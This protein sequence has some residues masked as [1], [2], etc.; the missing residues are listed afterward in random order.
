MERLLHWTLL[1][2]WADYPDDVDT[3]FGEEL[4][5]VGR[6]LAYHFYDGSG[7]LELSESLQALRGRA[8]AGASDRDL[9]YVDIIAAIIRIRIASSAW[10]T[11][12]GF[13]GLTEEQW[14]PAIRRSDFPKELWPSQMMLGRAGIYSG[15][16]GIVQMP[17]SAGK[18]RAVEIVLR[19]A[20]LAARTRLAVVVAPFRALC[21]EI[22]TSLRHAF[23]DDDV[24]VNELSDAMQLDFLE[25][26]AELLECEI[27]TSSYILS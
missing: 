17:T 15:S 22:G 24:K 6:L 10:T 19:S 3:F 4:R 16:S 1:A 7:L 20:F 23:G 14:A 9:L 18:T 21:H 12:P 25:Q 11:L 2:R 5:K 8:Y 13:T 27:P 26:V